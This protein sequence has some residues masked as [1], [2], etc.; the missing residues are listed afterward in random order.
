MWP[1][2]KPKIVLLASLFF[3]FWLENFLGSL[4]FFP[5]PPLLIVSVVYGALHEETWFAVLAGVL[6]GLLQEIT[7]SGK[8]GGEI[9]ALAFAALLCRTLSGPFFKDSYFARF[10]LPCLALL[11][12]TVFRALW[13]RYFSGAEYT[14]G[15]S[16]EMFFFET[17]S[18]LF[19]SPIIFYGLDHMTGYRKLSRGRS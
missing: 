11:F 9:L 5:S 17:A 15:A 19:I 8:M 13:R 7:A 10:F 2:S 3:L 6:A 12:S 14:F 16:T 18:L 4:R 1:L